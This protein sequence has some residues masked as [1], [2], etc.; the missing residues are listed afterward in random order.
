MFNNSFFFP[1]L[2]LSINFVC[3]SASKGSPRNYSKD[4]TGQFE[5]LPNNSVT[6]KAIPNP[7]QSL[8]ILETDFDYIYLVWEDL[9][10]DETAFIIERHSEEDDF[11]DFDTVEANITYY[12][13]YR[14][15]P[16]TYYFY[17]IKAL[18][19]DGISNPS[20]EAMGQTRSLPHSP[21]RKP[22]NL[23]ANYN[24]SNSILLSWD[25]KSD[26]ESAFYIFRGE[27][28]N[29]LVFFDSVS[30]DINY[31]MDYAIQSQESYCYFIVAANNYGLSEPTDTVEV[32]VEEIIHLES[33]SLS[34]LRTST[35][36][37]YLTW[38]TVPGNSV[39][40]QIIRTINGQD[41]LKSPPITETQFTD[42]NLTA[43]MIYHYQILATDALSNQSYSNIVEARTLPKFVAE[44]VSDSLIAMF[45]LSQRKNDIVQDF[46]W[47]GN[48]LILNIKDTLGISK[49]RNEAL[50]LDSPNALVSPPQLNNKISQACKYTDEISIECWIKTSGKIST[51][52]STV[53]A[54]GNDSSL[55]FSLD[56][57]PA[58]RNDSKIIYSVN[59]STITTGQ[60]GNPSF[61]SGEAI[62]PNVLNHVVYSHDQNGLEKFYINGHLAAEGY[63]PAGFEE[64]MNTYTLV[65]ANDIQH[66]KPWI[67]EFYLCSIYNRA[68]KESD[69]IANYYASPFTENNFVLNS[70]DYLMAISP[71]PANDYVNLSITD[72]NENS[73][74]TE[75][76]FIR[77][78]DS[79]GQTIREIEVSDH[80]N[81]ENVYIETQQLS[82]GI[83]SVNLYNQHN[84]ITTE[85]LLIIH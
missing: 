79:Y 52:P 33:P 14:V 5:Y 30:A 31:Y 54:F 37:V 19:Q 67:G 11:R 28:P 83:F 62:E 80:L 27:T 73:E 8:I 57:Q 71:N 43:N 18:N 58:A 45:I 66:Q 15:E 46:S 60:L 41:S 42:P 69:V 82:S 53:L 22:S 47:Y 63:R 68:L 78:T 85:K 49:T 23:I 3:I 77:I 29:T 6:P 38:D 1:A 51:E 20:N 24:G 40:Y 55:A 4:D 16:Y 76:Y 25:D 26:N 61:L 21:P 50:K 35:S 81:G 9:S 44:R 48:P 56:C 39:Q 74:I 2:I 7:P 13:D 65:L 64:W 32:M 72:Q 36:T 34:V 75:Q 84:L 70:Q 12:L 59:L 10:E 17:R